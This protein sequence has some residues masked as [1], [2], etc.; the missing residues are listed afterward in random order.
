MTLLLKGAYYPSFGKP[1][2]GLGFG[3]EIIDHNHGST[4][5]CGAAYHSGGHF[6]SDYVDCLYICN[7]VTGRVHRDRLQWHGSTPL[8]QSQPDLIS[9]EDGWFRPVD[10]AVGPDG[11]LYIAD[12]YNAIIGHYEVPLE[13]P[14][15]D[16]TRGR[17]WRLVWNGDGT[18]APPEMPDLTADTVEELIRRLQSSNITIRTLATNQLI[19]EYGDAAAQAVRPIVAASR[20][21]VLTGPVVSEQHGYTAADVQLAHALWVTERTVGLDDELLT[22]RAGDPAAIVPRASGTD[23]CR[24]SR[25]VRRRTIRR[26]HAARG[27]QRFCPAGGRRGDRPASA[28]RSGAAAAVRPEQRGEGRYAA[29]ARR[30]D[31]P[32]QSPA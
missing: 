5:I 15:R 19:D 17:I 25:M 10:V 28:C 9:S 16:R 23:P 26:T 14:R 8:V 6:P 30:P 32:A 7:P 1:H 20:E 3:P 27:R 29:A 21:I 11:A 22:L 31:C 13:H 24:A 2:D 18:A 4:G 12:F